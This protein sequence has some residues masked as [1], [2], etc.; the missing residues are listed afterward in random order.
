MKPTAFRIYD[1]KSIRDSGICELSGD[2]I[3][4]LAGQ[5]ESGKTAALTAL[6]DFDRE[7]GEKPQTSDYRPDDRFDAKPRVA[8]RFNTSSSDVRTWL[9]E[10][11]A[12]I[13]ARA[14]MEISLHEEIW[15]TRD[16]DSGSFSLDSELASAWKEPSIQKTAASLG[17]QS[18]VENGASNTT[19]QDDE[20]DDEPQLLGPSEFAAML[21]DRWPS[22]V[23]FDSFED[24][25]P[26][27]VLFSDLKPGKVTSTLTQQSS[28]IAQTKTS[29]SVKDF[30]TLAE[31]DLD[32]VER[33]SNEDK[34]LT[35]YLNSRGAL[36]TGDF[37]SY[38]KQR[39]GGEQAVDLRVR[40]HRGADGELQLA[41]YVHDK[42]DQYP[43]QRS[44]GFLWFLSFYLRLAAARN[45]NPDRKRVLLIDEPGTYLHARA[46]RDVLHLLEHRL[47]KSDQV[48]YSTHSPYLMP[49]EKLHRLRIAIKDED[50]GSLI[51]DRLTHPRL[52]GDGFKDTLSPILTAIG[53]D[54]RGALAFVKKKNLLVEGITDY[55]YIIA[56]S[57]VLRKEIGKEFNIFPGFG[58]STVPNFASLFVGWGLPFVAILDRDGDGNA[59][60]EKLVRELLIDDKVIV[61]PKNALTIEDL[62]SHEGF[63]DLLKALDPA[64]TIETS[65]TPA[66]AIRRQRIDKAL[67]ARKYAER[68]S[69]GLEGL[70]RKSSDGIQGFLE[71]VAQAWRFA[72]K[73]PVGEKLI[74]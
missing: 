39:V 43:E 64:F 10:E 69:G 28:Q 44:R 73:A 58:A 16:L 17:K 42:S 57:T 32:I 31:I 60:R 35:N 27:S 4:V 26:R 65:E 54:I 29:Q 8:V 71:E 21:R 55:Y 68:V 11:K 19:E 23:Y 1:F 74:A 7:E 24:I 61:Q 72:D 33:Y 5:N 70:T 52:R 6:R 56:W 53:L 49:T 38:Y 3:T 59:A 62:F 14:Y 46:Q 47:A 13:P 30:I 51:L 9:D 34:G 48:V 63:K 41:F 50:Q 20:S 22:F 36:I 15:V 45:R 40:H 2:G 67:L 18:D 37:L 66:K 25:L 12:R